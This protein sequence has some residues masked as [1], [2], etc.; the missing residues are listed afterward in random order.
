[1]PP[2]LIGRRDYVP[3]SADIFAAGFILFTMYSGKR[4]FLQADR[5]DQWYREIING[6]LA[7]FW[8]RSATNARRT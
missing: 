7:S 3:A 5:A 8:E 1:M 4:P 2:E 6:N